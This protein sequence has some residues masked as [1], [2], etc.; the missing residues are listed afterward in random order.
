[1]GT[2]KYLWVSKYMWV[3]R[4]EIPTWV[5]GRARYRIYLTGH[6]HISYYPYSWIPIDIPNFNHLNNSYTKGKK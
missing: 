6:G 1:M 3:T 2:R 5:W 4:K